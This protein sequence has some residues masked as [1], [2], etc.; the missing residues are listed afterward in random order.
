MLRNPRG[1]DGGESFCVWYTEVFP[2]V[3]SM[4]ERSCE[5]KRRTDEDR[6]LHWSRPTF[7]LGVE[8]ITGR[9]S[10]SLQSMAQRGLKRSVYANGVTTYLTESH[11]HLIWPAGRDDVRKSLVGR[12]HIFARG[13]SVPAAIRTSIIVRSSWRRVTEELR[14]GEIEF[15]I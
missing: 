15:V 11:D 6:R 3:D 5:R 8:K 1:P 14:F 10:R 2:A 4:V 7:E 12:G 9:K 13:R